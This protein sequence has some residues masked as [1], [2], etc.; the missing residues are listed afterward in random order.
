MTNARTQWFFVERPV[1]VGI[2]ETKV[3]T[4]I[5]FSYWDGHR[6]GMESDSADDAEINPCYESAWQQK[7]WRGLA[8]NPNER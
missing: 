1:H 4:D 5:S 6:F 2:Y 7:Q 8:E 3:S